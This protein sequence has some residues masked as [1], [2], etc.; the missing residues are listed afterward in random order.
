MVIVYLYPA[1]DVEVSSIFY[2]EESNFTLTTVETIPMFLK[3]FDISDT[4]EL[5]PILL[6]FVL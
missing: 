3:R 5:T 6:V 1:Y 4:V 2:P